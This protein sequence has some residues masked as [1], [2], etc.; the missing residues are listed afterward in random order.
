[1]VPV[2]DS[3]QPDSSLQVSSPRSNGGQGRA[4]LSADDLVARGHAPMKCEYL[5]NSM[6]TE[7][8]NDEES[9]RLVTMTA[10]SASQDTADASDT[11]DDAAEG[12]G[13][14]RGTGG[15][16]SAVKKSKKAQKRERRE[17]QRSVLVLCGAVAKAGTVD[18]CR[19]G[20]RCQFNHDI[21]AYLAHKP[22][23]LP[24]PCPFSTQ[25]SEPN[26]SRACPFGITC[27]FASSHPLNLKKAGG[28]LVSASGVPGSAAATAA[29]TEGSNKC[30][31]ADV[32]EE[33]SKELLVQGGC[34]RVKHDDNGNRTSTACPGSE[35]A[36]ER[37]EEGIVASCP[38]KEERG[39][40]AASASTKEGITSSCPK[41]EGR[42]EGG[43]EEEGEE[44]GT[45]VLAEGDQG[46]GKHNK[47]GIAASCPRKEGRGSEAA[48]PSTEEGITPCPTKEERDE[49]GEAEEGEEN[50]TAVLTEGD[51]GK[52]K[53]NK[54]GEY[55]G[56]TGEANS[57]PKGLRSQLWKNKVKFK[58]ANVALRALGI[59][60]DKSEKNAND[61]CSNGSQ[62]DHA[63]PVVESVDTAAN[64]A[65]GRTETVEA[66]NVDHTAT[67]S[68]DGREPD[69]K[70]P[71]RDDA[72]VATATGR[73]QNGIELQS[74]VTYNDSTEHQDGKLHHDVGHNDDDR[75]QVDVIVE[76]QLPP[77]A[78]REKAE[79][80]GDDWQ[81]ATPAPTCKREVVEDS[82]FSCNSSSSEAC[83]MP[84][85]GRKV[86]G[87]VQSTVCVGQERDEGAHDDWQGVHLPEA[88]PGVACK[89][90]TVGA[91]PTSTSD[92]SKKSLDEE[93]PH[94][95][96][97][98]TDAPRTRYG[99]D[100][101][102]VGEGKELKWGRREKRAI[103]FRGKLYLAPLTTVGNLP[104]RRV[105][106]QLGA[107]VT[108][109]E[110]A[111]ATN[112]LQGQSSEWALLR[113]HE[114]E[115]L[116]GVQ[117]CGGHPDSLARASELIER[118]CDVDF[119]DI[120]MGCPIDVVCGKGAGSALLNKVSRMEMIVR[121]VSGTLECPLTVKLRSGYADNRNTVHTVLP[122]LREWG[123]SAATVHP[124]SRQQ[125]YTKLA[126]WD[127]LRRKCATETVTDSIQLVGNGDLF[128]FVDY[129]ENMEASR[130]ATCMIARGAL[131]KPWLFTE[132]KEQRHWDISATERLE[133]L[134]DY[135]RF[136]LQHWGSDNQGVETTRRFLLEW[137]SF[138]HRYIPVG[139]LERVPQKMAWRPPAYYGR[140][141]L[142]TLMA[143][144]SAADW[145][146]ISELLLGPAPEYFT[147]TPK[148]K[149]NA[150]DSTVENG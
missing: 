32:P 109:G 41:E 148:H 129:N 76:T 125:R 20:E 6:K 111:M 82:S 128:S 56:I 5:K 83:T 1:M 8:V 142:E 126:D 28:T 11:I 106:K 116:F 86:L 105:C 47:K 127:Y 140:N 134:K 75:E 97:E 90:A 112:L 72:D 104:F 55:H 81:A 136:G 96:V 53:R 39:S 120:N 91:S 150:Y 64:S 101:G 51:Q 89:A 121:A 124:R 110:M 36:S 46:K 74:D 22:A 122:K 42:D 87:D 27:R 50:G 34:V 66:E 65:P 139:L 145:V 16:I 24:G 15:K 38:R 29:R 26:L 113:R 17:L 3:E 57:L 4:A 100:C 59:F 25:L 12:A 54:K 67:A 71:S 149:S 58:R 18:G 132:I 133:L 45:D 2:P 61:D 99:G 77:S 130:L 115:D 94:V 14:V 62:M 79:G 23:D 10:T 98:V 144:D 30:P 37:T 49:V 102:V 31:D 68:S 7:R 43:E 44:K 52:G 138:L 92:Q 103:D 137:L 21:A 33:N 117:I 48:S 9:E 88:A 73:Q 114:S 60:K 147:F 108:C 69:W 70:P 19:F 95:N 40:E 107:D 135:C 141:D 123:A 93:T 78:S 84:P 146:R 118:V 119:V 13:A 131:I 63:E 85:D 143:S 80:D 35:A